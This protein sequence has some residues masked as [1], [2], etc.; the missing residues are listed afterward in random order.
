MA[1][2]IDDK[3]NI[4]LFAAIAAAP[5]IIG[6]VMWLSSIDSKASN[7][8]VSNASQEVKIETLDSKVEAKFE[9][10]RTLT[11][12]NNNRLIRIETKLDR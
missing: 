7:A 11:I 8:E 12:D 4:P 6:F 10:L 2:R 3:T 1:V 9:E 5:I